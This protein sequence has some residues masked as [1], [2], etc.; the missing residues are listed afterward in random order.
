M[1][2]EDLADQLSLLKNGISEEEFASWP[3]NLRIQLHN[4]NLVATPGSSVILHP[5][6]QMMSA[7]T[8]TAPQQVDVYTA[9]A[10][11]LE[12]LWDSAEYPDDTLAQLPQHNDFLNAFNAEFMP[13]IEWQNDFCGKEAWDFIAGLFWQQRCNEAGCPVID[14]DSSAG[15]GM[16]PTDEEVH[17]EEGEHG[18]DEPDY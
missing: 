18:H 10:L 16:E 11:V 13:E 3:E 8:N 5:R 2:A 6:A 7:E 12:K 17:S 4:N 1:K 9:A 15:V 14:E